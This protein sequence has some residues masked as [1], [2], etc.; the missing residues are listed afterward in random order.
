MTGK[1]IELDFRSWMSYVIEKNFC[2]PPV[3]IT[4]DGEP[5]TEEESNEFEEG[6]DPCIHMIRPYAD[7]EERL[8][9]EA[10]HPPSIWRNNYGE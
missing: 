2:G 3:C 10:N 1:E 8:A 4:H 6:S 9:V 5:M 7:L